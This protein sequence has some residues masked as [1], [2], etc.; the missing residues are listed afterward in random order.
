LPRLPWSARRFTCAG[1]MARRSGTRATS[2]MRFFCLALLCLIEAH[3]QP[4]TVAPYGSSAGVGSSY[5]G[6]AASTD[7]S[8]DFIT[9]PGNLYRIR[10]A[11]QI[12]KV[13]FYMNDAS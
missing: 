1:I 2:V 9:A 10:Q 12:L 13:K 8:L 5:F 4:I 11:G 7:T 3:G 6:T